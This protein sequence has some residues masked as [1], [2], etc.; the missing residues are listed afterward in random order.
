MKSQQKQPQGPKDTRE[1][2]AL[3]FLSLSTSPHLI[4]FSYFAQLLIA[5]LSS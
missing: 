4:S 2:E 5:Y 1:K 3:P